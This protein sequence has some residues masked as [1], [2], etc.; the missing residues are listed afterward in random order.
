MRND[1]SQSLQLQLRILK[2][3]YAVGEPVEVEL[4]LINKSKDP[5]I[6]NQRMAINPGNMAEGRWEVQFDVTFPPG[7]RLIRGAKIRREELQK[8]DFYTLSP[9][10]H[11]SKTYS[12]TRYYWMELKGTYTVKAIYSNKVSGRQFGLTAWTG[13][14]ISN[15]I[16]F[17]VT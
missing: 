16:S 6:V 2:E 5:C 9:G 4:L 12:L 14:I 1:Q 10:E 8:E 11:I 13:E 3:S 17:N 15:S 7:K